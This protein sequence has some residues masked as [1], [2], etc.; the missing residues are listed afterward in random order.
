MDHIFHVKDCQSYRYSS[1]DVTGGNRDW[2]DIKSGEK[3][4][5]MN[6]EGCGI[7]RRI[8]VTLAEHESELFAL[9]KMVIRMYWDNEDNPSVI[10]PLGD[11]FGLAFGIKKPFENIMQSASEADGRS[12]NCYFPMPFRKNGKIEIE[13]QSHFDIMFYYNIDL[14][15]HKQLEADVA[16]FHSLYRHEMNTQPQVKAGEHLSLSRTDNPDFPNW[17]PKKW[18]K[19]NLQGEGNYC[20]V[21]A[22]GIGHYVGCHLQIDHFQIG[23]NYWYG[24]GDEMIW[25]DQKYTEKPKING[26]GTEDYF[27]TAFCPQKEFSSLYH[28]ITNYSGESTG[29]PWGRKNSMYKLHIQD[30]VHFQ[31]N[32]KVT[33]ETGHGNLMN[34]DYASVA[35]WYQIEPHKEHPEIEAVEKRI[36]RY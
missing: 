34:M 28:G 26:T 5:I 29:V 22:E 32:I 14:E 21:E 19:T 23:T 24:E 16:Y 7:I 35:Y 33:F 20:V 2:V 4:T 18:E 8:W 25:I 10:A 31:K 30:P 13:N 12:M 6:H 3:K 36:P 17:Y 1:Y 11:F 9:R 15:V 27:N